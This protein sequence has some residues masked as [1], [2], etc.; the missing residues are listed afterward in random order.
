MNDNKYFNSKTLGAGFLIAVAAGT[1]QVEKT[2]APTITQ[3][4]ADF[5][6]DERTFRVQHGYNLTNDQRSDVL[7]LMG[8]RRACIEQAKD[9]QASYTLAWRFQ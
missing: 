1:L 4:E 5:N 6:R 8:Q 7:K 9:G 2:P 3:C